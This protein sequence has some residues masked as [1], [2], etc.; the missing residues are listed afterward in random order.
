MK[1][2]RTPV[3]PAVAVP[4]NQLLLVSPG[5]N[6]VLLKCTIRH[7]DHQWNLIGKF[8]HQTHKVKKKFSLYS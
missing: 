2:E 1:E 4:V 7:A 8:L 3:S 5:V 6:E